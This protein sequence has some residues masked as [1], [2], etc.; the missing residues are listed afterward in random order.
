MTSE[1]LEKK[2]KCIPD[3]YTEMV[4]SMLDSVIQIINLQ[5]TSAEN[6]SKTKIN[7]ETSLK[8]TDIDDETAMKLFEKFTGSL[9]V[10]SDFDARK[11]Y[12]EYLDERYRK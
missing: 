11:E 10:S 6:I 9:K 12:L 5:N 1:I 3:E 4:L 2:L 7:T 8:T